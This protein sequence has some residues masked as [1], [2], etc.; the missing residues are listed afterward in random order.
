[1]TLAELITNAS[2][3][4]RQFSSSQ[5]PLRYDGCDVEITFEANTIMDID[6]L[7]YDWVIDIKIEKNEHD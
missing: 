2:L 1:M 5:I 7:H 4:G 3:L 6:K